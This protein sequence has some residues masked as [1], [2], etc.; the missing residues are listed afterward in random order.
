MCSLQKLF[1]SNFRQGKTTINQRE[2]ETWGRR[3]GRQ[4]AS[5]FN[6]S[7]TET[8]LSLVGGPA[9]RGHGELAAH[10]H[11]PGQVR[12]ADHPRGGTGRRD[13][14]G[15]EAPPPAAHQR[16]PPRPEACLQ[17]HRSGDPQ[18]HITYPY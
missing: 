7:S 13:H 17:R 3:R 12:R 8:E 4:S 9:D 11:R 14:R 1:C 6:P 15:A 18:T 2:A 16:P 5:R 10:H